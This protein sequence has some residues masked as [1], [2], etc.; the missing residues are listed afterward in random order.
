M[1]KKIASIAPL[2]LL[3]VSYLPI[4]PGEEKVSFGIYIG[5]ASQVKSEGIV[6]HRV[7]PTRTEFWNST[8][9]RGKMNEAE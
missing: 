7:V 8:Y 5:N 9:V 1:W 4:Y 2:L 6:Y 3:V